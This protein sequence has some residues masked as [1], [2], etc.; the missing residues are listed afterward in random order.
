MQSKLPMHQ[1]R[2]CR[3]K[4]KR[5]GKQCK[6]PAVRGKAVCRMHGG[7]RGSGAPAGNSNAFRHGGY[8][9]EAISKRR[10]IRALLY[11]TR[12]LIELE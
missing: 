9:A 11:G 2:R 1:A 6:A 7:A 3:A 5:S 4:S 10:A 12:K 8:A